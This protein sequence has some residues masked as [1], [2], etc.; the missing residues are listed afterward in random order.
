MKEKENTERGVII[1]TSLVEVQVTLVVQVI[2]EAGIVEVHPDTVIE[3]EMTIEIKS[4]IRKEKATERAE[5]E[6][7]LEKW[8]RRDITKKGTML[9]KWNMKEGG[10]NM[11]EDTV[12]LITERLEATAEV[13]ILGRRDTGGLLADSAVGHRAEIGIATVM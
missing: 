13:M 6:I 12:H 8:K 3:T 10:M 7:E 1:T 4:I 2:A 5:I 9:R 11:R